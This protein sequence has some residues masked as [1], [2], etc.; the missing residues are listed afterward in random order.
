MFD[1]SSLGFIPDSCLEECPLEFKYLDE[2]IQKYQRGEYQNELEVFRREIQ[3]FPIYVDE[4]IINMD[5]YFDSQV[6]KIY[7]VTSI[8]SHIFVWA[9]EKP[10]KS[11]PAC[12]AVPWYLSSQRLGIPPV[13]THAAVDLYNWRLLDKNKPPTIDNLEPQYLFN[14]DPE[15]RESEKWFYLPLIAIETEC[16][17]IVQIMEDVY[18]ILE[19]KNPAENTDLILQKLQLMEEKMKRQYQILQQTYKCNPEHFYHLIRPYLAGSVEKDSLGWYLEGI[20]L[21][22]KY[23]GGS[24]AQSSLIQAEDIFLGVEHPGDKFLPKMREYMPEKH[25]NFLKYQESRPKIIELS[26]QL[27]AREYAPLEEVRRKCVQWLLKFRQLH[28]NIV[29]KYVGRFNNIHGTGGTRYHE[30]LNQ[31]LENTE[32]GLSCLDLDFDAYNYYRYVGVLKILSLFVYIIYLVVVCVL[33]NS[34]DIRDL[35]TE[36]L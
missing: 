24:A 20:E 19:N 8:L 25:R 2:F 6:E 23:E 5:S 13:L 15:V 1:I 11:I 12:L 3:D 18:Q 31:Y 10:H 30:K 22:V 21:Y 36:I 32:K 34:F 7:S 17:S 9:G 16:G 27:D 33:L 14:I 29:Q 35:F 28:Y 26:Y 4:C